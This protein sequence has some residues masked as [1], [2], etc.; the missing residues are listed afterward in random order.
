VESRISESTRD[1]LA[2]LGHDVVAWPDLD[3]HA[4]AVCMA[5]VAPGTGVLEASADPRTPSGALGW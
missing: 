1:A 4:G 2:G 3:W 5:R